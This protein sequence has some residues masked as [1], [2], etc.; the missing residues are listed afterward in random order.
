MVTLDSSA[1]V[2]D[3]SAL[4]AADR[5][6]SSTPPRTLAPR[7]C[8]R[9]RTEWS[10]RRSSARRSVCRLRASSSTAPRSR[11]AK[12]RRWR[13]RSFAH[14]RRRS[15]P[16]PT[17]SRRCVRT[18]SSHARSWPTGRSTTRVRRRAGGFARRARAGG[19]RA[20]AHARAGREPAQIDAQL[21]HV[22]HLVAHVSDALVRAD[23]LAEKGRL[24]E[25]RSGPSVESA[26]A[27]AAALALVPDHAGAL[28]GL[29]A[30]LEAT[31]R[32][33][34]LAALL[35]RLA[36][37]AGEPTASA[38][39]HVERALLF[40]RRLG[41]SG[42]AR[43]V[44]EH[45]VELAPGI[46]PVRQAFV[47][48]AVVHRDDARLGDAPRV[49]GCARERSRARGGARARRR[50][51]ACTR[52]TR[53]A[54]A[55]CSS[56]RMRAV[57]RRRSSIPASRASSRGSSTTRVATPMRF[58]CEKPRSRRPG[59][60][61]ELLALRAVVAT[62]ERARR[63]LP[64]AVLA[65]ER[66]RVLDGDDVTILDE[67]DRLLVAAG[68]HDSR[69]VL[70][71]R[72]AALADDTRSKTHALLIASDAA[73]AAGRDVDAARH[74]E[75]AWLA[76]PSAPG[77]FDALAERLAA[78]GAREAVAARVELY[79]KAAE[80]TSDHGKRLHYLEKIA[81][82]WDDVAGDAA[83]AAQA[84]EDVLA[85]DPERRSAIAGLASAATRARDGRHLARALLAEA[86]VSGRRGQ[87]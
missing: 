20:L 4:I 17:P 56:T 81:W 25:A 7:R 79:A 70:W 5:I 76:D 42:T 62:A 21:V 69:A 13:R 66:A 51:R 35:G 9:E 2:D 52:V 63:A 37:L 33:S 8:S 3:D 54:R 87:D 30:A 19:P 24:L 53:H 39:L 6:R 38:W 74:R 50:A 18:S 46:G 27:Y 72:E 84:Y 43:A 65:L 1:L 75:A 85:I 15:L 82:L 40:D 71:M 67:L 16:T 44:L 14:A 59:P 47:D 29:E 83:R 32:W 26:A 10:R 61:V 78:A 23:F 34:E 77:V 36:G 64:D 41:D 80:R 31:G 48:H 58:A 73:A 55:S 49:R 12:A 11:T 28:A 86:D 60:R 68:R 57:G 45:A 22:E